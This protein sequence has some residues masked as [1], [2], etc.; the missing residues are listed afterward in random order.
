M[1]MDDGL[2]RVLGKRH[3]REIINDKHNRR[4]NLPRFGPSVGDKNLLL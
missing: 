1:S 4:H 2:A 3:A